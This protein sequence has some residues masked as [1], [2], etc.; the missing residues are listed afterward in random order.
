MRNAKAF[1]GNRSQRASNIHKRVVFL[2]Y[3]VNTP[4]CGNYFKSNKYT[5]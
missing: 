3:V 1:H 4:V 5:L 2:A